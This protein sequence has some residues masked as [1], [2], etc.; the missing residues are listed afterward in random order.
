[1][2]ANDDASVF[3]KFHLL[4]AI[5]IDKRWL[6]SQVL[7]DLASECAGG[8]DFFNERL[9]ALFKT[10]GLPWMQ[11]SELRRMARDEYGIVWNRQWDRKPNPK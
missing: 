4:A 7:F 1:M 5:A 2:K 9:R 6:R 8:V 11:P 10:E 3:K